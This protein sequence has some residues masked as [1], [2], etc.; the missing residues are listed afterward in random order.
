[1]QILITDVTGVVGRA[2]ARQ[3]V[4]AGHEV[5][6]IARKPHELLDP[7]VGFV[8]APLGSAL[9]QA[10][11]DHA[12]VVV[13]L[14]PLEDGVPGSAGL[15]GVV[16][17]SYAAARAGARLLFV[18]HAAGRTELY[19]QA[20]ELVT[21]GWAP[22]L[23]MRAAPLAGRQHD[24]AVCRTVVTVLRTKASLRKVRLLHFDDLIR[25][26][27]QAAATDRTGAVDLASPDSVDMTT[28]RRLLRPDVRQVRSHRIPSWRWTTPELDTTAVQDDWGF[29]CGWSAAEAIVDTAR[30][31]TGRRI[32]S[33]GAVD[34]SG[35]LPMP[36]KP[37]PC[38]VPFDGTALQCAAP[39]GLE[40][41]FDDRIDPHFPV[42]SSTGITAALPGPLTPMT[43]DVQLTGLR[44]ASREMGQVL[45]L[46]GPVATE[47]ESRGIAVF[48][49]RPYIGVSTSA[50]LADQLP[51][52]DEHNLT[53]RA[54]AGQ[55]HDLFP[56]GRPRGSG[57]RLPSAA[58]TTVVRRTLTMLRH[59][60]TDTEAYR[61]AAMTARLEAK[62]LAALP[63]AHLE[64]RFRLLRDRIHQGWSLIAL[65]VIDNGITAAV[66]GRTKAAEP[67]TESGFGTVMESQRVAVE[68]APFA[69]ALRQDPQLRA[70][71]D[72]GDL[73]GVRAISPGFA[74]DVDAAS[75]RM[76]HRGPGEVELANPVFGDDRSLLLTAAATANAAMPVPPDTPATLPQRM[77][78]NTVESRETAHDATMQF[79]HELRMTLR[80]IGSRRAGAE[81][82]DDVD[83]VYYLT[84]DELLTM[85]ADAR[86]RIKR[87]RAE[88]DRLQALHLPA[89]VDYTWAPVEIETSVR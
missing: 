81:L 40:G 32:G 36:L 61:A 23:I 54:L 8:C 57:S 42:F 63:S 39:D 50:I 9:L 68:T 2:L 12:D 62:K 38:W 41:E 76:A 89:V 33:G 7:D 25:F 85:P 29:E 49:H 47:W 26:L 6:G 73:E 15:D 28:A 64:V 14:A 18:S 13:H 46:H 65:W 58:K 88:R 78:T 16:Q 74:A 69:E 75:A 72:A 3:L 55:R 79:T 66:V 4:A 83:D 53:E 48:G 44:I 67:S 86:L 10:L 60:K 1:M 45:A 87:R 5:T 34:R 70:L 27:V 19:Q 82:I 17:V 52:W 35:H 37:A 11:T 43:I 80:E 77:A 30:G 24:W 56:L 59:L 31:L 22:S 84:C 20:E 21:S 51:G 71:A